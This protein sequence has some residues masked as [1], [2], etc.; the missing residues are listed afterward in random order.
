MKFSDAVFEVVSQSAQPITPPQIRDI[1]KVKHPEFYATD[2]AKL[3]V[4]KGHYNSLDH[5]LLAKVYNRV[6]DN[7]RYLLDQSVKPYTVTV[8]ETEAEEELEEDLFADD[9]SKEVG[10]VY[11]LSTGLF[12]ENHK[13]I[14]KIGFTTQPLEIRI[15]DLYKTGSPYKFKEIVSYNVKN[16]QELERALH[17]LLAPYRLNMTREFFVEDA[18]EFVQ[19]IVNIHIAVQTKV[20]S[21]RF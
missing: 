5:A 4:E 15:N 6:K 16:Y 3:N 19:Q 18:L 1:I 11:V 14:I 21:L 9:G 13:K 8:A 7:D 20:A 12:T 17:K 10:I 2:A